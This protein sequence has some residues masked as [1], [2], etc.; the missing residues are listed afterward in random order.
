MSRQGYRCVTP[1][2]V[3]NK[4]QSIFKN[5]QVRHISKFVWKF[6]LEISKFVWKSSIRVIL[7]IEPNCFKVISPIFF[8]NK[9]FRQNTQRDRGPPR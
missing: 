6:V 2:F 8:L 1:K 9:F 3:L 4:T 5:A 7:M